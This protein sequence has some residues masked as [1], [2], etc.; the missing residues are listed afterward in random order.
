MNEF[1]IPCN[2][3]LDSFK[4]CDPRHMPS[5]AFRCAPRGEFVNISDCEKCSHHQRIVDDRI[6]EETENE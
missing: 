5:S 6:V 1:I 4:A 3:S 2:A